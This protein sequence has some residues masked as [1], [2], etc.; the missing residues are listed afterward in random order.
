MTDPRT[1][2]EGSFRPVPEPAP[3]DGIADD[4]PQVDSFAAEPPADPQP[5]VDPHPPADPQPPGEQPPADPAP[6][7]APA[8]PD[9]PQTP[10]LGGT[11]EPDPVAPAAPPEPDVPHPVSLEK[12]VTPAPE[13]VPAERTLADEDPASPEPGSSDPVVLPPP[14]GTDGDGTDGD[15]AERDSTGGEPAGAAT[16]RGRAWLP[17]AAIGTV[18]A[19]LIAGTGY[20]AWQLR[21]DARAEQAREEATAAAR[22]AARLLFSYN[23]ETLEQDFEKGLSVTTGEFR[24]QY[25]RTTVD[26]VTPVAEQ[27]DAV[28]VA[29]VIE[30]AIV[31][32]SADRA[33]A[34]VFLNQGTTSTRVQGQQVDQSRVRMQLVRKDGRWLVE[35]VGA[36]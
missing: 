17:L 1:P 9:E 11:P 35:G 15:S 7:A 2:D 8:A 25:R 6:A 10:L 23:H 34:L 5:P 32:A 16:R 26:V 28:V 18:V 3:A 12:P 33:T 36:L 4:P 30:A 13:D 14:P 31:Q 29:E 27:Y 21:Q 22:D 24:D 20:L 19:L